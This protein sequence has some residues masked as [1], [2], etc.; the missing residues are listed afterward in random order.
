MALFCN[1]GK[2]N[3]V[4]FS[5]SVRSF[6]FAS[7]SDDCGGPET[8]AG[9]RAKRCWRPGSHDSARGDGFGNA[10]HLLLLYHRAEHFE[11]SSV[12]Y[13]R[14]FLFRFNDLDGGK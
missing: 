8:V 3:E 11:L 12:T 10:F 1:R 9:R 6:I 14:D 5:E 4:R 7:A 2:K 13:G